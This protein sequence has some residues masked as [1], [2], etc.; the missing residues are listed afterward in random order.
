MAV[1]NWV[2]P[3]LLF[4]AVLT[5]AEREAMSV[6]VKG[7]ADTIRNAKAA[8]SKASDAAARLNGSAGRL[9][10]T[11]AQVE[12]MTT[13]LDTANADLQAA[14]G[15]LSNGGPPL[16][17]PSSTSTDSPAEGVRKAVIQVEQANAK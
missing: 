11:L 16:D 15:Q 6:E 14:V 3:R 1:G 9:T 17:Q 8:I 7:L 13:Q 5:A 12:D 4:G 10:A 2:G